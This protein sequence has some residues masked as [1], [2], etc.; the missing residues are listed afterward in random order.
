M[1]SRISLLTFLFA[2]ALSGC[3]G[4]NGSDADLTIGV[5]DI[6]QLETA[7]KKPRP[8]PPP[9][10][11]PAPIES[12]HGDTIPPDSNLVDAT[13]ATWNVSSGV[14][15][16]NGVQTVSS[17]VTLLLY[18]NDTVYQQNSFGGWWLWENGVG[19]QETTDPRVQQES[20]H[21]STIPPLTQIVDDRAATWTVSG[22]VIFRNNVQTISGNVTL[23]LYYN[24][25]IYQQNSVGDWY[26][27]DN[28]ITIG[29]PWVGPVS[30]PRVSAPPPPPP[31]PSGINLTDYG[32]NCNGSFNNSTALA[33][34]I[35]AARA[36]N[37]PLI[38]PAGQC[39]FGSVIEL[40]NA[41]IQGQ[42]PTSV[43][44]ATNY[45][46]AAIFMRGAAPSVSSVKL[47]GNAAPGR[48]SAWQSTKITIFGATDFVINNVTI[49]GAPAA[50]IQTAQ[51][52]TRGTITNNTIRNSLSDSIHLTGAASHILVDRNFIEFSGDDGIA[53]VS[54]GGEVRV[55]NITATNNVIRNNRF[56]RNMSVVGGNNITYRNN[57]LHT[58][59]AG[60]ACFLVAQ[61][62]SYPTQAANDVLFERNTLEGN[63]G[64]AQTGHG[65][66]LIY[67]DGVQ[68]HNRITLKDNKFLINGQTGIRAYNPYTFELRLDNNQI[69]GANPAYNITTPNVTVIPYNHEPTGY[70]AP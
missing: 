15:F 64:S 13:G 9:P 4:G 34:G 40:N 56:G 43:L 55:N 20:P 54:Y 65:A 69:V 18:W 60:Y 6:D 31:P 5:S 58:N 38:I 47:T 8:P 33:N 29:N 24:K 44:Y 10:P 49:E 57:W 21:N 28:S 68:N 61:E 45:Q 11:P 30:D 1:N 41:K 37:Q 16:R 70:V 14:I 50:S 17:S 27:W 52:P 66:T 62:A 32:G 39:N 59:L 42:G 46:Q 3:G 63:C 36:A 48:Q 35:A 12:D 2:A 7:R 19:W 53:V 25:V 51:A 67:S 26:N 22:G 23:L